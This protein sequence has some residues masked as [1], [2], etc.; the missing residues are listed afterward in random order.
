MKTNKFK[1]N[2]TD[3]ISLKSQDVEILKLVYRFRFL[4]TGHIQKFF[5]LQNRQS[6]NPRLRLLFDNK[7]LDRPL[8]QI[9]NYKVMEGSSPMVYS[10]GNEGARF[11]N[12]N[13]G[14][15]FPKSGY[16]TEKNRVVKSLFIEHSLEIA[17]FLL[18]LK[19][20]V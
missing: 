14:L 19:G 9:N 7:F 1:R 4:T 12:R 17:D 11:L 3:G 8:H 6:I 13:F 18:I 20:I 2:K 5:N 16:Q 10:V 15:Y